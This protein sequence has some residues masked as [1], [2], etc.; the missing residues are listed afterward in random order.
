MRVALI[1]CPAWG[2]VPPLGIASLKS[3]LVKFG[4]DVKCFDFNIAYYNSSSKQENEEFWGIHCSSQW[5]FDYSNQSEIR[6]SDSSSFNTN[7]L[8][9][10]QWANEI[11]SYGAQIVGFSANVTNMTTGLLLARELKRLNPDIFVVFGGPSVSQDGDIILKSG[12]TDCIVYGEGE[13]TLLEIVRKLESGED[14]SSVAGIGILKNG[15]L[16]R[17][18]HRPPVQNLDDLPFPDFE[19]FPLNKYQDP[20]RIPIMASR[21][22]INKCLY[23]YETIFW[24]KFR[25]RSAESIVEE[26]AYRV[27]SYPYQTEP[28]QHDDSD[29]KGTKP[30]L[31]F[32]FADSLV[33]GH[34]RVLLEMCDKIAEQE[35]NILWGGQAAIDKRM[36][37]SVFEKLKLSGC[38]SLDFGLESGSQRVLDAM[39][40]RF[41]I[42]DARPVIKAAHEAGIYVVVNVMVGFPSE[43]FPDFIRTLIFI[44][45]NYKWIDLVNNTTTTGI[46]LGTFLRENPKKFDITFSNDGSWASPKTGTEKDRQRRLRLL[47]GFMAFFGIPHTKISRN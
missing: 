37:K 12:A 19:D 39:N 7:P 24:N 34:P 14:L 18:P 11:L 29:N 46:P 25:I 42:R 23:C 35:L 30:S 33:N 26:M 9:L 38:G 47:H 21:G 22:C 13:E 41:N 8:P 2:A 40:K 1:Q 36:N 17:A 32:L 31:I 16:F 27:S 20:Y 10:T 3:F 44:L 6:F 4:Y 15:V 28:G 43:T 5:Y 45:K